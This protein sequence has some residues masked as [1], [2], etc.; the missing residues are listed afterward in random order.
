L[1]DRLILVSTALKGIETDVNAVGRAR[2]IQVATIRNR[3]VPVTDE[4]MSGE[5]SDDELE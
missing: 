2:N 3:L 4:D 5:V 1:A